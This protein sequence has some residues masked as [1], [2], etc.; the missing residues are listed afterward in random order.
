MEHDLYTNIKI[1]DVCTKFDMFGV[2]VPI[3][4]FGT[5]GFS[6]RRDGRYKNNR[7]FILFSESDFPI[8]GDYFSLASLPPRPKKQRSHLN[9]CL[10]VLIPPFKFSNQ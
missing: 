9:V 10:L 6:P 3:I 7:S 5:V 8:Q 4:F 2:K 1:I